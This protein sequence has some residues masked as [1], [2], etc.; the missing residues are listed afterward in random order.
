[1]TSRPANQLNLDGDKSRVDAFDWRST[2]VGRDARYRFISALEPTMK[3]MDTRW[4]Y[5]VLRHG[6][7]IYQSTALQRR[8]LTAPD[9]FGWLPESF[10]SM[11][12]C[13]I[14]EPLAISANARL[15]RIGQVTTIWLGDLDVPIPPLDVPAFPPIRSGDIDEFTIAIALATLRSSWFAISFD[16][17]G[18]MDVPDVPSARRIGLSAGTDW[19]W[20]P[21]NWRTGASQ[22]LD[23]ITWEDG[24][25]FTAQGEQIEHDAGT[26]AIFKL[27]PIE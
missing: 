21:E 27:M 25:Q 11:T 7:P 10:G 19:S 1:M 22:I 24:R 6:E 18:E 16:L 2:D 8:L 14:E 23:L 15:Y 5:A 9:D 3:S 17:D 12:H 26:L 4:A 13:E 20:V